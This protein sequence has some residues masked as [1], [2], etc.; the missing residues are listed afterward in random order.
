MNVNELADFIN[1]EL[2]TWHV[3]GVSV[4]VTNGSETVFAAG[5]GFRE[6]ESRLPVTPDT[7]H[8]VASCSKA[9]T[10]LCLGL[11]VEDGVLRWNAPVRDYLPEFKL[12]DSYANERVTVRDL[13][14]HRSGL[15]RHDKS[16]YLSQETAEEF[17]RR[18]QHLSPTFDF[19]EVYQYNNHFY[20]VAAALAC[21]VGGMAFET[22]VQ[23]RILAPL[24]MTQSGYALGTARSRGPVAEPYQWNELTRKLQHITHYAEA[25]TLLAGPGGLQST[26]LDMTRWLRMQLGAGE[27]D[28]HRLFKQSTI[29]ESRI[30]RIPVVDPS[31]LTHGHET[32]GWAAYGLGWRLSM[33]RG[34]GVVQHSGSING[35]GSH[36]SFMPGSGLGVVVLGNNESPNFAF[37]VALRA[38]D[39]MLGLEPLPWSQTFR[40]TLQK[41]LTDAEM[42]RKTADTER[43][44]QAPHTHPA[45]DY[46]GEYEHPGYGSVTITKRNSDQAIEATFHTITYQLT[47]FHYDVFTLSHS[48]MDTT[49]RAVFS[50]DD[51]GTIRY[52]AIKWEAAAEPIVFCRRS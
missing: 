12:Q 50:N 47:H 3:P 20:I 10:A 33:Y 27:F 43:I 38:Y 40:E 28:G 23:K 2:E 22:L 29:L 6:V 42:E 11:L 46:C 48:D 17:V 18:I 41:Q 19:R 9:F 34:H 36:V 7:I 5:Y 25:E 52:V 32:F 26:A 4:A 30:P 1:A 45:S 37:T 31:S 15:P 44:I 24:G 49:W 51:K 16:W 21:R 14:C 39:L 8:W 13:L 35:F